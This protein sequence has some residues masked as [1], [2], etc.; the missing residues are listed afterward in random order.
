MPTPSPEQQQRARIFGVLFAPA[1][2]TSIAGL[3]LCDPVLRAPRAL[4]WLRADRRVHDDQ[5]T[6]HAEPRAPARPGT[7]SHRS[8]VPSRWRE[9]SSTS[10]HRCFVHDVDG[11]P[12]PADCGGTRTTRGSCYRLR[13]SLSPPA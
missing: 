7:A 9:A 3:L 10:V 12:G 2:I 13:V 4:P 11:R 8:S 1:F 6:D 5:R